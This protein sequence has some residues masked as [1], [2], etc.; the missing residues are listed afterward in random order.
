[1]KRVISIIAA[2]CLMLTIIM[3]LSA[4]AVGETVELTEKIAGRADNRPANADAG[5][6]S[7]YDPDSSKP[8][9]LGHYLE[10]DPELSNYRGLFWLIKLADYAPKITLKFDMN[11]GIKSFVPFVWVSGNKNA[12]LQVLVSKDKENWLE[13]V[14]PFEAQAGTYYG[15]M[16]APGQEGTPTA[17]P[18]G[19]NETNMNAVLADNPEKIIYMQVKYAGAGSEGHTEVQLQAFGISAKY[20]ATAVSAKITETPK[21]SYTLIDDLDVSG[22]KITI[23]YSDESEIT[24]NITADMV[25][26]FT[27]ST[28]GGQTLTVTK[29]G[30]SAD[31]DIF[32]EQ[33]AV[34]AIEI[35]TTPKTEYEVGDALDV[36]DGTITVTFESGTT[37]ERSISTRMISGFDTS[38]IS[39]N[40]N[41]TVTYGGKTA[42]YSISVAEKSQ[43]LEEGIRIDAQPYTTGEDGMELEN[44]DEQN[45]IWNS[46]FGMDTHPDRDALNLNDLIK[47]ASFTRSSI[48]GNDI[49]LNVFAGGYL[50]LEIDLPNRAT[51]FDLTRGWGVYANCRILASKDNG[52]TWY[53][54]G[55][56]KDEVSAMNTVFTSDELTEEQRQKNFEWM[57]VGNP[58]KKFLLKFVP[59]M[60]DDLEGKIQI[61]NL[62]YR[63]S[64]NV[65]AGNTD[66]DLPTTVPDDYEV[67]EAYNPSEGNTEDPGEN[68]NSGNNSS[69]NT[70]PGNNSSEDT[71]SGNNNPGSNN[72]K[73]DTPEDTGIES[74]LPIT[75]VFLLTGNVLIAATVKKRS[76]V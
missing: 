70:T 69:E 22:G 14:S 15:E 39:D 58:E 57:L 55:R 38:A 18:N 12:Q 32:I 26:G 24:Y 9:Y 51:S 40:I 47:E 31:Y 66:Q 49:W 62:G 28:P 10:T 46:N 19:I 11:N 64:Y 68:E 17:W 33:E 59:D 43:T 36:T 21:T 45:T 27:K 41:V 75:F 5:N 67:P 65:G 13:I 37:A 4:G 50:T 30:V 34:T 23:S 16:V 35:K 29:Q 20:D 61:C 8:E 7:G 25:T 44:A 74:A 56:V 63:V 53:L 71:N 6:D 76:E 54:V 72:D 52:Q 73:Q 1:M 42:T 60:K 3:P 2:L 48:V